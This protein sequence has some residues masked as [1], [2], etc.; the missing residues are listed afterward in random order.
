MIK[1][2]LEKVSLFANLPEADLDRICG[3]VEEVRLAAGE[4][5]FAEGSP[6]ERAYIIKE[7]QLEVIKVS[8]GREVLLDVQGVGAVIGE[9]ALLEKVPRMAAVRARTDCVLL[10]IHQDQLDHLLD[11]SAS[12]ARAMLRTVLTRWRNTEAMLR[13]SER[14]AQL[15]TLSAGVAHELNNPAAAVQ[16]GASQLQDAIQQTEVAYLQLDQFALSDKEWE[17]VRKL[18]QQAREQA[19]YPPELDALARSDREGELETWL[20]AQGVPDAWEYASTLVNL[21]YG[22]GELAVLTEHFAS[23]RLATVIRWLDAT[24]SVSSLLTEVDQG[25]GRISE[26]VKALKSYSYLDQAP[27]QAVDLH[28]GLDD[29]LVILRSKLQPGISVRREY[30]PDLPKIQAYGSELNQVWTNILD[31]AIDALEGE[32][33]ITIRTRQDGKWVVVEIEDN[34]PG[35]P[36]DIQTRVFD[37]FFTTKPPGKGTGLGLDISYKIIVNKHRGDI[38]VTSQPGQT[39]FQVKLP[40]NF[41]AS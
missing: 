41:E 33:Q 21:S 20:E 40:L 38:K 31:N 8:G 6:G 15:G 12:A 3:M 16:R 18:G 32:G 34:G 39:S 22:D 29:T 13:Q 26:I 10:A 30:A 27:V 37:S 2:F 25:A 17:I 35:I 14:M 36:S 11:T 23:E 24:Y 19:A 4:E 28:E 1:E 7:G 5:L 9:M